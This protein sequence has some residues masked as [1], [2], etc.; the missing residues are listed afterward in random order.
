MA[1][2]TSTKT[3]QLVLKCAA[4][5]NVAGVNINVKSVLSKVILPLL[6]T[7]VQER[8]QN[9]LTCDIIVDSW[10]EQVYKE[11]LRDALGSQVW[12][13]AQQQQACI[14]LEAMLTNTEQSNT[15]E[16]PPN[17]PAGGYINE[18]TQ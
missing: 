5:A 15:A 16:S 10:L 18:A 9:S 12:N 8:G 2:L 7:F 6:E 11:V 4:T 13:V 14:A 17:E 3:H 1:V